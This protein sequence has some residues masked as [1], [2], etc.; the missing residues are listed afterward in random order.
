VTLRRALVGAALTLVALVLAGSVTAKPP[1]P[2]ELRE[3]CVKRSDRS[4]V[5][6]FRSADGVRLLGVMLG[7]GPAAVVL[8]HES[9]GWI[10]S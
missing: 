6:R 9:S 2:L 3:T 4:T 10:C 5:V 7:R 1:K 8:T